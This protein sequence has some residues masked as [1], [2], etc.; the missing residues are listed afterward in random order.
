MLGYVF[1]DNTSGIIAFIMFLYSFGAIT[2][3]LVYYTRRA[4]QIKD[5]NGRGFSYGQAFGFSMLTLLLSGIVI[6]ISTWVL[7]NVIDPEFYNNLN[8]KSTE[9]ILSA[10]KT[11]TDEEIEAI[12]RS[13]DMMRTIW[14]TIFGSTL[15]IAMMGGVVALGTSAFA[16]RSANPFVDTQDEQSQQ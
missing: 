3:P 11:P 1:K 16:K 8:Q 14:G 7:Q 5:Y 2:W 15:A 9:I 13:Q 4:A 10:L 6:G 12:K